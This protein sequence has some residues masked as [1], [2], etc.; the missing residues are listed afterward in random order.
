M[1]RTLRMASEC[2]AWD[3]GQRAQG[4]RASTSHRYG[5]WGGLEGSHGQLLSWPLS[6]WLLLVWACSPECSRRRCQQEEVPAGAGALHL[7]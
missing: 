5:G 4:G 2:W 6:M 1:S 3:R 7:A